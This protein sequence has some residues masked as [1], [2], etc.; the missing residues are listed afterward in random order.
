MRRDQYKIIRTLVCIAHARH[1]CVESLWDA[2]STVVSAAT[3]NQD[4]RPQT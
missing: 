3:F 4:P 1:P 2:L